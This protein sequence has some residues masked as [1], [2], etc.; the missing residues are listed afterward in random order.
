[1]TDSSKRNINHR[2]FSKPSLTD[3]GKRMRARSRNVLVF[4]REARLGRVK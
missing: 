1:M 3:F 4:V 2:D